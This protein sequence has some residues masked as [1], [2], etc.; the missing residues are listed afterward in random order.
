MTSVTGILI[1][2]PI[3]RYYLHAGADP[4]YHGG[5]GGGGEVRP[6]KHRLIHDSCSG[7]NATPWSKVLRGA[8]PAAP[9]PGSASIMQ[10]CVQALE[11]GIMTGH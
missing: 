3:A 9:M 10:A 11:N 6:L 8:L 4:R 5:G 2:I 1:T 7:I